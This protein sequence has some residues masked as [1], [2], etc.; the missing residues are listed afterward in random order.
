MEHG[1]GADYTVR[2][3]ETISAIPD[4]AFHEENKDFMQFD[5]S[6]QDALYNIPQ[7]YRPETPKHQSEFMPLT[8]EA[9]PFAT[10]AT[11]Q[12]PGF[13]RTADS[14]PTRRDPQI[15]VNVSQAMQRGGSYQD[16]FA[17]MRRRPMS[18]VPSPPLTAPLRLSGSVDYSSF[19]PPAFL[20]MSDL[21]LD[22][23]AEGM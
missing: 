1:H 8:P 2:S 13:S 16:N 21:N 23:A 19:P 3:I 12:Q 6:R 22:L 18:P 15:S 9:T 11:I 10:R 14:S 20:N 7:E 17:T 5:P 4:M